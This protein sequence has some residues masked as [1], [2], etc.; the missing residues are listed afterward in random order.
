MSNQEPGGSNLHLHLDIRPIEVITPQNDVG[1]ATQKLD[2]QVGKYKAGVAW[3]DLLKM[4]K[5]LKFGVYNDRAENKIKRNK[6]IML[7]Q[8]SGILSMKDTAAIKS[9]LALSVDFSEPDAHGLAALKKYSQMLK[10]EYAVLEKKKDKISGLTNMSVEH[11]AQWDDLRA[12]MGVLLRKMDNIGKWGVIVYNQKSY[13]MPMSSPIS[14]G[15]SQIDNGS[16]IME[17]FDAHEFSGVTNTSD[18]QDSDSPPPYVQPAIPPCPADSIAGHDMIQGQSDSQGS[19]TITTDNAP[20]AGTSVEGKSVSNTEWT[21]KEYDAWLDKMTGKSTMGT[22]LTAEFLQNEFSISPNQPVSIHDMRMQ[23]K[24]QADPTISGS[25]RSFMDSINDPSKIQAICDMP[26]VHISMPYRMRALDH[27][28][29]YEWNETTRR[30]IT[31]PHLSSCPKAQPCHH[32]IQLFSNDS[33]SFALQQR[34]VFDGIFLAHNG[35]DNTSPTWEQTPI[36]NMPLSAFERVFRRKD[37][38]GGAS[39][40]MCHT[41]LCIDSQFT[42][43]PD[44]SRLLWDA[45]R[46]FLDFVLVAGAIGLD[47][48]P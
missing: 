11:V 31:V 36:C 42:Y 28:L 17:A 19:A 25:V 22:L 7:F 35:Q 39:S 37:K 15:H 21:N 23:C 46:H 27:G 45:S 3:I 6:L 20:V 44:D 41:N 43:A 18:I 4:A 16:E 24:G 29:T 2:T 26:Q 34:E 12:Q 38:T 30:G 13:I 9:G 48:L 10:D 40:L 5:H 33:V 32:S 14:K 8:Q 47:A 1:K